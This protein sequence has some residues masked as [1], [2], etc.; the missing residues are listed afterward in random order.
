MGNFNPQGKKILFRKVGWFNRR[1][2]EEEE[3]GLPWADC[4]VGVGD[5]E[6]FCGAKISVVLQ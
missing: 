4:A 3:D 2:F 1:K 6:W 5:A